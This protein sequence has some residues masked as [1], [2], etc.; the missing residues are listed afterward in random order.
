MLDHL[1]EIMNYKP[2]EPG[3]APTNDRLIRFYHFLE[4]PDYQKFFVWVDFEEDVLQS[5]Y[6]RAPLFYEAGKL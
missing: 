1:S 3:C 2:E 6:D 5:N 4:K